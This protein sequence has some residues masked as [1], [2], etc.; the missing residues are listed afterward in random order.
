[1]AIEEPYHSDTILNFY[2]NLNPSFALPCGV[3]MMNPYDNGEATDIAYAFYHR[4]YD[5][6]RHRILLFGI[7][8]GRFG[9]GVTGIPFTDPIRLERECGIENH[10]DKKPELSS[11]FVYEMITEYGGVERFYNDFFVTAVCPLGFTMDGKNL[12]YYDDK[13]LLKNTET[14]IVETIRQQKKFLSSPEKCFCLGKGTN[15]KYFGRLNEKY[16][17]FKNI[18]PLPHPRWVM[19]YRRKK[20]GYFIEEYVKELRK[21]V[22]SR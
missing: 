15:Y 7:N 22:D 3:E 1:M 5:D 16:Q 19:Q 8:P 17:F 12:N 4:F 6:T 21:A 14:F 2:Q 10:L 13:E 11:K 20:K 9:A 18:I